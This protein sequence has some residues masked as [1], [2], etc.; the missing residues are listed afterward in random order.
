MQRSAL[1]ALAQ[2]GVVATV[3]VPQL[4]AALDND[5]LVGHVANALA[6]IGAKAEA[7]VPPLASILADH[8]CVDYRCAAAT[9]LGCIGT[10]EAV[11]VVRSGLK[12]RRKEVR[13]AARAALKETQQ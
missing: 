7:A 11:E 2:V 10:A 9:A 8:E 6:A 5:Q 12:D 1:D 3:A 13:S 4:I